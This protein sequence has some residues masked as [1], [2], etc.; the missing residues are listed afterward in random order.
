MPCDQ[1][2]TTTVQW[3]EATDIDLVAKAMKAIGLSDVQQ[4]IPGVVTALDANYNRV[5]YD[6]GRL[7]FVPGSAFEESA[8]KQRYAAEVV[9]ERFR[10]LGWSVEEQGKVQTVSTGFTRSWE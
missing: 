1:V 5:T 10:A 9:Q 2:R 4:N 3:T 8:L 6:R 7:T